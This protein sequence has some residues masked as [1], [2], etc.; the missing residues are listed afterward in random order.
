VVQTNR[1]L[2]Y[3]CSDVSTVNMERCRPGMKQIFTFHSFRKDSSPR[4][5][6][7][8]FPWN[9][10]GL[11]HLMGAP[12]AELQK[13]QSTSPT[14]LFTVKNLTYFHFV[15]RNFCSFLRGHYTM[16]LHAI[17]RDIWSIIW[18]KILWHVKPLLGNGMWNELPRRQTLDKRSVAKL[19]NSVTIN[20][21]Y[22]L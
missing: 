1:I 17:W 9:C 2:V 13:M 18:N 4:H 3:L 8:L 21:S 16:R 14:T 12:I 7:Q 11:A 6:S 10:V 20:C 15:K 19:R 22:N 5:A